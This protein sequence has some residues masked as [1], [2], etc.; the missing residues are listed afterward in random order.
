M[1]IQKHNFIIYATLRDQQRFLH[2]LKMDLVSEPIP[3]LSGNLNQAF[4]MLNSKA[5][6]QCCLTSQMN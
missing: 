2:K 1:V 4:R 3:N 6:Q 5:G